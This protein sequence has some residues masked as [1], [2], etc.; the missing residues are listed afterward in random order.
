MNPVIDSQEESKCSWDRESYPAD[1]PTLEDRDSQHFS[2]KQCH[3]DVQA[4]SR[5][6]TS[7]IFLWKLSDFL[8]ESF[9]QTKTKRICN[10]KKMGI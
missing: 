8:T 9:Q 7:L 2:S 1:Q 5:R 3:F 10:R 6:I 4:V